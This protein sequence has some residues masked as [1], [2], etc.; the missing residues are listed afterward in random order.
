[1]TALDYFPR[2]S[3]NSNFQRRK[4]CRANAF[5]LIELL[6][7]IAVIAIL[8]AL[9]LPALSRAK[10]LA[11]LTKCAS[12]VRQIGLASVMYVQDYGA[13]PSYREFNTFR[14]EFWPDKLGPYPSENW[15]D[16]VYQCPANPLKTRWSS[17]PILRD[18]VSYDIN[19]SG[20]SQ[21]INA[22]GLAVKMP[23]PSSDPPSGCKES[24]VVSPSR[25]IAYGDAVLDFF[26]QIIPALGFFAWWHVE[27]D[28]SY[29]RSR[30]LMARRHLGEWNI[31]FADGHLEHFK[32]NVLFGKNA[33]DPA[34]EE[35]RRR[36]NRDHEPHWEELPH[37]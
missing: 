15:T 17:R 36:W 2:Y 28:A 27:E 12:N 26:P 4:A 25:M 19:P 34:D 14:D 7:V 31:A 11:Q 3:V 23:A 18:G 29:E 16:D 24:Q 10:A 37:P 30:R 5:T 13:Y 1:M 32:T 20:V 35:M 22:Y 6:V 21:T 9:L 8:A 33:Y